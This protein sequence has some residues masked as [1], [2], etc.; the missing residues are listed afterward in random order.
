[1]PLKTKN[2]I[3]IMSG[4]SLDG[5]DVA[6]IKVKGSGLESDYELV[7]YS[8]YPYDQDLVQRILSQS[9]VE[10]SDVASIT[11]LHY[12]LGEVYAS[13]V[14]QFMDEHKIEEHIDLIGLHG[15]TIHHLP[16]GNPKSTL[17]IGSASHLAFV[18][19]TTVVSNFREM[20]IVAGGDGAPLVP[21]TD[22]MMFKNK[23]G[24]VLLNIGG[25]ANVT[26]ISK[27]A[28]L[29]EVFAFDTGP[30]NMMINAAM[31]YF[32]QKDY[33]KD[34]L[35][36]SSGE[37]IRDLYDR[38][39]DHEYFSLAPP[40]STGREMFGVEMVED[41]CKAYS[42][43]PADVIHTLTQFTAETIYRAY[44]DFIIDVTDVSRLVVSGGGAYNKFLMKA[45]QERF[46]IDVLTQEDL[47]HSS[48][49]KEA[50]AFALLANDTLEGVTNNVPSATGAKVPVI[51]GQ[52]TQNPRGTKQ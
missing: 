19:E 16:D 28:K 42:D 50:I 32:Y 20:D 1:M 15:Q 2:I 44:V 29:D 33:D 17:Q 12:E 31:Q 24:Q 35:V 21:Y 49:A 39:L 36:A 11:Q 23:I 48:D 37:L 41:I 4:T 18:H 8:S 46:E 40:K 47:G 10:T 38:L 51:L 52:I 13:C 43:Q 30:G 6:L 22:Y 25:I 27:D 5:V 34:G 3:G 7:A 45:L 9:V 14:S 26:V